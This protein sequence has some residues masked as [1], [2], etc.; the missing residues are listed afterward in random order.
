MAAFGVVV[1][2]VVASHLPQI[3]FIYSVRV[4]KIIKYCGVYIQIIV[5]A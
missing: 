2:F 4:V 3:H 5:N 1:C